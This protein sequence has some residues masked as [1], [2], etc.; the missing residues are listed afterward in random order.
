[1]KKVVFASL[2]L[3]AVVAL[4]AFALPKYTPQQS[5]AGTE[6]KWYTWD[7]AVELNKTKPKK[8]MIDV[9]TEWCGWCKHMD[10]NTFTDAAVAAYVME[11]FYPVKLD[12]EQR[13]DIVFNGQTFKFVENGGRRGG[14]HTLA[15][16]LLDGKMGY[17]SIVYLTETYERILISPGYKDPAALMTELKF[18][19]SDAFRTQTWD[20][21]KAAN[22]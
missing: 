1:M 15:Y 11:N 4:T 22:E 19:A 18:T 8:M 12:A 9:F 17:P 13:A 20:D 6:I 5:A 10:K 14:V 2:A 3:L 21:Y 7:E 16:S